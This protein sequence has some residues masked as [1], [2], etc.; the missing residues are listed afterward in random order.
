MRNLMMIAVL[1]L[2]L[3]ACGGGG[4]DR[5]ATAVPDATADASPAA[6]VAA[7]NT[8]P[9]NDRIADEDKV[10]QAAEAIFHGRFDPQC[11]STPIS[12]G[13]SCLDPRNTLDTLLA[14]VSVWSVSD[15]GGSTGY[16]GVLG[17]TADGEWKLWF[18]GQQFYQL[19]E[20]PGQARV[21]ADGQ[22]LNLRKSPSQTAER[23][24]SIAD[25]DVVT[26]DRFTL[27]EPGTP[28]APGYGWYHLTTN[29]DG[30]AY[31]KYLADAKQSNCDA[32]N[33]VEAG[34]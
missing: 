19:I 25:G 10:Q 18:S 33:S 6:T 24:A 2:L 34:R 26:A 29:P 5:T 7:G 15:A 9:G 14:G 20:L 16:T 31:S 1:A 21:C 32:R 12:S 3:G 27:T 13:E 23:I 8:T 11:K 17:R 30:W 28:T 22:G 4:G